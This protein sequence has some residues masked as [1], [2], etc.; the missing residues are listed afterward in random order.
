MS[1][2]EQLKR[3]ARREGRVEGR[4]EGA[5]NVLLRLLSARFGP[6]APEIV[7]RVRAAKEVELERWAARIMHAQ[8][9]GEV[10]A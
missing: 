1:T 7:A 9:L 3:E 6:P 10:L 2:A 4:V 5:A 8:T